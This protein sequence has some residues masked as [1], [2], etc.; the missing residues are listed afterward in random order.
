MTFCQISVLPPEEE[1]ISQLM[2]YLTGLQGV[3]PTSGT[4]PIKYAF[5]RYL[6]KNIVAIILSHFTHY[7]QI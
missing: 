2:G 1:N 7:L 4:S 6:F 5:H 3:P